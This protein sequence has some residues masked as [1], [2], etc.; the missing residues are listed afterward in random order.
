MLKVLIKRQF[1]EIFRSYFVNVKTNKARSGGQIVGMFVLFAFLM[2]ILA[3]AFFG[4]GMGLAV[5]MFP[6]N[7]GWLYY[8]LMGTLAIA[9]GTFGSVFNTYASLYLAKDNDL[10]LSMPIRPRDILV[11]RM[12]SVYGLSLLY[13]GIVWLPTVIMGLLFGPRT[14]LGIAFSVLLTL[15]IPLFVTVLTCALGFVVAAV[16]SRLKNKAFITVILSVVLLG[17]YYTVCFRLSDF[18]GLIEANSEAVGSGI[19]R[20]G[21]F[22]YQLGCAA[23]GRVLPML[24]FTGV[25]A[26]LTALCIFILS[27]SFIRIVTRTSS[28]GTVAKAQKTSGTH[29][30][31]GALLRREFKRFTSSATYMLNC[32]LGLLFVAAVS[33][34]LIIRLPSA[35]PILDALG[36]DN[37]RLPAFL[38]L[39]APLILCLIISMDA[40]TTPSVSLE[41]KN[42]WILRTLPVRGRE[43]LRAKLNMGWLVNGPLTALC[44]A[45]VCI[46]LEGSWY[47]VLLAVVFPLVFT[48][49]IASIGLILGVKHANL[50][51]TNEAVPIK[52]SMSVLVSMLIGWGTVIVC[53]ALCVGAFFLGL[54]SWLP[55]LVCSLLLAGAD[56]I[57]EA[58][59]MGKGERVFDAL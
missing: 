5:V 51:W 29:S 23:E 44:A 27:R 45:G 52:Q 18:I 13:S 47:V 22:I 24:I 35:Q 39:A 2:M 42:L 10:L 36:T 6:L 11:A 54:P 28:S 41:G 57:A 12:V 34:M 37:A 33:V 46:A 49:M 9:L 4:M 16:A 53:A 8:A 19:R 25:T 56:A 32:G 30:V 58:W 38:P 15:I 40:V 59:L 20:Y 21:N 3:G 50:T 14:L 1:T 31:G 43:V 7:M 17:A 55:L 26:V 48:R